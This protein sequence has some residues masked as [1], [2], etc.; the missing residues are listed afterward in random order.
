MGEGQSRGYGPQAER[1]IKGGL[2]LP[3]GTLN[4]CMCLS[5]KQ[6]SLV[7]STF[8]S[9]QTYLDFMLEKM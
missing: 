9:G 1:A 8:S 5:W 6:N 3:S 4:A 7:L 2:R